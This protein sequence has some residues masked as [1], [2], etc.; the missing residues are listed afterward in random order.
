VRIQ[1]LAVP[2]KLSS[3]SPD[4]GAL[5]YLKAHNLL[6]PMPRVL[7][8]QIDLFLIGDEG[9]RFDEVEKAVRDHAEA[10]SMIR[11]GNLTEV[12][13]LPWLDQDWVQHGERSAAVALLKLAKLLLC[14]GLLSEKRGDAEKASA[15]YV[16]VVRFGKNCVNGA[17]QSGCQI[18]TEIRK[19]GIYF[20]RSVV[21][22]AQLSR[23]NLQFVA[24]E[25]EDSAKGMTPFAETVRFELLERKQF[26]SRTIADKPFQFPYSEEAI[27]RMLDAAYGEAIQKLEKP[28]WE[29]ALGDWE[30]KWFV[31]PHSYA[32]GAFDRMYSTHLFLRAMTSFR[33]T[34]D[35]V[36]ACNVHQDGAIVACALRRY[37]LEHGTIPDRL[38]KLVPDFLKEVPTDPYDGK[39]LRFKATGDQWV[40]WS[41]GPDRID[42]GAESRVT[43]T[44][45]RGDIVVD[46]QQFGPDFRRDFSKIR[47][48]Q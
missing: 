14:E 6:L 48:E 22:R 21:W 2:P 8:N 18:G 45:P 32:A 26:C 20:L 31:G 46:S 35:A 1:P 47:A 23:E 44:D 42:N 4:N 9:A 11:K 38:E 39:P 10:L 41:I 19:M 16:A 36:L 17:P 25:L 30:R 40:L 15:D 24:K 33:Q 37:S 12:C 28:P 7:E 13:L 3:L 27:H 34:F 43:D 29:T 5:F